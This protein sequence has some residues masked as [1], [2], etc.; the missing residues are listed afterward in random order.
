MARRYSEQSHMTSRIHILAFAAVA[1]AACGGVTTDSGTPDNPPDNPV[2]GTFV[3]RS[4]S[5]G[6]SNYLYQV[7]IPKTYNTGQNWPVMIYL[8]GSAGRGTDGVSM[9]L[10]GLGPVVTAQAAT[11]P[12]IVLFPQIPTGETF[13]RATMMQICLQEL[14]A[15]MQAYHGDPTR[16]YLTGVSF[17][18]GVGYQLAYENPTR[19]A[20]FVPISSTYND[21]GI[22][23]NPNATPGSTYTMVAQRLKAMA[24]WVHEGELDPVVGAARGIVAAL[25]AIGGNVQYTEYPG[26]GHNQS[27]WD[28]VYASTAFYTWL[29]AQHR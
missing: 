7:F 11:F 8:D 5:L 4:L 15:T 16:I 24:V 1:L 6:G 2:P 21:A 25:Q 13:P 19:F 9:T 12:A 17:G 18:G 20:A 22:T 29:Y 28:G 10:H 14:D 27:I 23:S 3:K 26:L